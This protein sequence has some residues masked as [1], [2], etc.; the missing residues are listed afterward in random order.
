MTVEARAQAEE[1]RG[2]VALDLA[3]RALLARFGVNLGILAVIA[4]CALPI[5]WIALTALKNRRD[6]YSTRVF[7]D[8]TIDNFKTIFTEPKDFSPLLVNSIVVAIATVLIGVPI[9]TMAAYA[10]SR[11]RFRGNTS[12]FIWFLATQFIPPVAI[13]LP[14]F[15]LFQ[16]LEMLDT[17]RG[18]V[19]V[20]L[21][22]VVPYTIW[23][24]KGFIDALPIDLEEAAFV[25][26]CGEMGVIRHVTFPL[27]APG[28]IVSAVFA[29][30]LAWNEFL[31][32]FLLTRVDATTL[33]VGLLTTKGTQGVIWEEMA[34]V[35][36]VVMVPMLVLSIFIRRHFAEGL[37]LGAVK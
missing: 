26:G 4:F 16:D 11:L 31:F 13:A 22:I 23:L 14:F 8:L 10:F 34:A 32:A 20:N 24:V 7:V 6:V 1:L 18:L 21:A 9:A 33:T 25:D 29:F 5:F 30:V 28:I 2:R 37:T 27:I 17:R 35:G 3:P 36:M 15:T 19:I 12:L